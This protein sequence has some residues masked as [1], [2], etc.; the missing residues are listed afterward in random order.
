M[1]YSEP[2]SVCRYHQ[3]GASGPAGTNSHCWLTVSGWLT[4]NP[5]T[6]VSFAALFPLT[7]ST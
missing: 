3:P 4:V 7:S 6:W 1:T 2:I 5:M